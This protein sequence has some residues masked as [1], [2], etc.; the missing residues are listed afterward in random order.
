M[1]ICIIGVDI[2]GLKRMDNALERL[3]SIIAY[4]KNV[5]QNKLNLLEKKREIEKIVLKYP[6]NPL[7]GL[8]ELDVDEINVLFSYFM[9]E[10]YATDD[11]KMKKY[12]MQEAEMSPSLY[13]TDRYKEA[14]ALFTKLMDKLQEYLDN[15]VDM[16]TDSGDY[17]KDME[18]LDGLSDKLDNHKIISDLEVYTPILKPSLTLT[19]HDICELFIAMSL[20][21]SGK[22]GETDPNGVIDKD[23]KQYLIS[24]LYKV[25][26]AA[27]PINTEDDTTILTSL[28]QI[29]SEVEND[30]TKL[31][32][33][34]PVTLEE[35]LNKVCDQKE[36]ELLIEHLRV[37]VTVI[38]GQSQGLDLT[39]NDEDLNIMTSFLELLKTK[40]DVLQKKKTNNYDAS[41]DLVTCA[42]NLIDKL[43][44]RVDSAFNKDD[45]YTILELL[46]E[47]QKTTNYIISVIDVLN[48]LNLG[49]LSLSENESVKTENTLVIPVPAPEEEKTLASLLTSYG[50]DYDNFP[51]NIL[52]KITKHMTLDQLE[53]MLKYIDEHQE[54]SFVKPRHY[55][56]EVSKLDQKIKET[57]YMRLYLLLVYSNKN[58]LDN[59]IDIAKETNLS[60]KDLFAIPKVYISVD[61]NGTYEYFMKNMRLIRYQYPTILKQLVLRSPATLGTNSDLFRQNIDATESYGMRIEADK[62][63]AFPSPRALAAPKFE[64]VIDRYIELGEFDYIERFR[65]QLETNYEVA[66]RFRYL[67]IKKFDI[68]KHEYV[69]IDSR[70]NDQIRDYAKDASLE[71]IA[72]GINDEKIKWLDSLNEAPLDYQNIYYLL[73]GIYISR[74]KVLKYFSTLLINNYPDKD[75]A[76]LYSMVKD[77]FLT[78]EEFKTIQ[79]L[80]ASRRDI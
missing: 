34:Y 8:I 64:F 78:E 6:S 39:F 35:L 14:N 32:D 76:L 27:M 65:N 48:R 23:V 42:A 45:F 68:K 31:L 17:Q 41:D 16:S 70:F 58:I 12:W 22:K 21:N 54:L 79:G 72:V 18:L 59:L 26:N 13:Q 44:G 62:K 71:N 77:S 15:L 51:K 55:N 7:R 43:E 33:Y 50:Y 25:I 10:K 63:G 40:I 53:D 74:P 69:N 38:R 66:L 24:L 3:K 9:K 47:E 5:C 1:F 61:D 57:S 46:E 80:F 20:T 56:L 4:K 49:L 60:V 28:T 52:D 30:A 37:P 36:V 73:K 11:L 75:E 29:A 67:Q 2:M 19:S